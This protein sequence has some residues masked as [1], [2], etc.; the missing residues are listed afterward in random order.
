MTTLILALDA[1]G[2]IGLNGTLPW[3]LKDDLAHFKA[4]TEGRPVIMGRATWESLPRPLPNR[5]NVIITSNPPDSDYRNII[6][7]PT[8]EAALSIYGND[9]CV[10][11]GAKLAE[12]ALARNLIDKLILTHVDTTILDTN[13]VK[14]KID[15]SKWS[16]RFVVDYDRNDR[17]D[18]AFT[19]VE[20]RKL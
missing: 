7:L 8:L 14:C 1:N 13:T 19:I 10:I 11:G 12:Y 2:V 20:Y 18:H 15:M 6:Y 16:A 4:V 3:N 9:V 5:T 17:N